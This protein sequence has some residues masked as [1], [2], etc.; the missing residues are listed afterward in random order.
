MVYACSGL[1]CG[2]LIEIKYSA[3]RLVTMGLASDW[4]RGT[5]FVGLAGIVAVAIGHEALEGHRE[6]LE[7]RFAGGHETDPVDRGR[8]VVLV[9][10]ALGVPVKVFREAFSHVTPARPGVEPDPEQVQRNKAALLNALARY[11][12]TN[13]RLDE[14]SNRYR[15]DPGRGELWPTK[16]ASGYA[17]VGRDGRMKFIIT[18]PGFGYSSPPTV[19]IEGSGVKLKATL[20]FGASFK[21]NGSILAVTK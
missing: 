5:F 4:I 10:G 9:A 7:L 18:D 14:V 15:Y 12:V 13:E 17:I 16:P 21:K 6:R 19:T 11:G 20:A 3:T 1:L 8:P 2:A